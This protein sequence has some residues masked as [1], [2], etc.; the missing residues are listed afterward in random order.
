MCCCHLVTYIRRLWRDILPLKLSS[1]RRV[2]IS[3]RRV[4]ISPRRVTISPR[5]V[6][7]L[8]SASYWS[9]LGELLI[10]PWRVTD[11]ASASYWSHLGGGLW[12]CA[13][14]CVVVC[15]VVLCC[16]VRCGVVWCGVVWCGVVWCDVLCC[17]VRCGVWC[18]VWCGVWCVAWCGVM[19]GVVCG[20]VV[21]WCMVVRCG[22]VWCDAWWWYG[23]VRCGV[24]WCGV[25]VVRCGTPPQHRPGT[26]ISVFFRDIP[27]TLPGNRCHIRNTGTFGRTIQRNTTTRQDNTDNRLRKSAIRLL[28]HEGLLC[29]NTAHM[30]NRIVALCVP[31]CVS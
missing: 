22:V 23:A 9:R 12:W 8:A 26:P 13:V 24:V 1:P 18:V 28:Q 15:C 3:P 16:V 20:M 30:Y 25:V 14:V 27:G 4:T 11:L 29:T 31:S 7:D 10:S 21:V 6:T 17:A 19:C 5:R 2:V